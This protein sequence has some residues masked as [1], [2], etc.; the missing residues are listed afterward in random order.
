M[1]SETYLLISTIH[2]SYHIDHPSFISHRPSIIYITSTINHSYHINHQLFK[3]H[4]MII[5][6]YH[7]IIYI[8]FLQFLKA[9]YERKES[10]FHRLL[11]LQAKAIS[12]EQEVVGFISSHPSSFGKDRCWWVQLFNHLQHDEM[13]HANLANA[14]EYGELA[15]NRYVHCV[16]C[17]LSCNCRT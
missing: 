15:Y 6:Y 7:L 5:F 10:A 1:D 9:A 8:L 11:E 17:V 2:H 16:L 4:H 12:A 13:F 14:I 3:S